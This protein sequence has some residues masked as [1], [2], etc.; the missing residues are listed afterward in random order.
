MPVALRVLTSAKPLIAP[1]AA[2]TDTAAKAIV[3]EALRAAASVDGDRCLDGF[4]AEA[5]AQAFASV[6]PQGGALTAPEA[7][8]MRSAL[9]V[10]LASLRAARPKTTDVVFTSQGN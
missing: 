6:K 1:L 4:E 5:V 10:R 7:Q 8:Q 2:T 9:D 3:D